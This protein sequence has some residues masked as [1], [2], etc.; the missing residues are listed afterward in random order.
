LTT[1]K[2]QLFKDRL[3]RFKRRRLFLATANPTVLMALCRN[4]F[5]PFRYIKTKKVETPD[6]AMG[7][8]PGLHAEGVFEFWE[9]TIDLLLRNI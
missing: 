1:E 6:V 7:I 8:H 9:P 3:G 5:C 2:A 4:I